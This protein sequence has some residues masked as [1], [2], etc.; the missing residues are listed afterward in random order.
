MHVR[1]RAPD[2]ER[3]DEEQPERGG[4][5]R[6]PRGRDVEQREEDPVV[7]E[8][9]A[10]VVRHEE[11]EHRAAPDDEQRPPILQPALREHLALLAQVRGEEDDE[12]DLPELARLELEP[13][14]VHPEARAVDRLPEVTARAA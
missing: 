12:R 8:R 7:E 2:R 1:R 11:D 13:A 5:E 4:D 9:A 3:A 10:E 6:E 14:D